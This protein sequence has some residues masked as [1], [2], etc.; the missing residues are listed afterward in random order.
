MMISSTVTWASW[1]TSPLAHANDR[2]VAEGDVHQGHQ[3]VDGHLPAAR[4]SPTQTCSISNTPPPA[5][6]A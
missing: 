1:F 2:A 4:Q 6:A 5:V 3:L